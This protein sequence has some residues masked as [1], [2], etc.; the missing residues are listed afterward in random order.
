MEAAGSRN[1]RSLMEKPGLIVAPG[2]HDALGARIAE[3]LGFRAVYMSGNAT[4]PDANDFQAPVPLFS[5]GN[6]TLRQ[7]CL[8]TT[9]LTKTIDVYIDDDLLGWSIMSPKD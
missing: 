4:T 3:K 2:C 5:E 1:L 8:G 9:A 7:W 6:R